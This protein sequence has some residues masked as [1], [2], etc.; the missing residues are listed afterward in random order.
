[1]ATP[2]MLSVRVSLATFVKVVL[3]SFILI[4][5]WALRDIIV[6][7]FLAM[8]LAAAITPWITALARYRIPRPVG[9]VIVYSVI[10]GLIIAVILLMIPVIRTE[11]TALVSSNYYERL[12]TFFQ[13][14]PSKLGPFATKDNLSVLTSGVFSGLKGFLGGFASFLLVLVITFYFTID[15]EN[16]RRFWVRLVPSAHR[17]RVRR[18]ARLAVERIGHWFRGQLVISLVIAS[19]SYLVYTILGVPAALLLAL[20]SGGAA[21]VP[22]IGAIIGIVPAVLLALTVSQVTAVI[23]LILG[24]A[25]YQLTANALIPKIMSRAVGLNPVIIVIV[26]LIGAQL[27]GAVGLILA[28]PITSIIDVIV[29]EM[30][31]EHE[32]EELRHVT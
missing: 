14:N 30:R 23:V 19:L 26:M 12:V 10:L 27:A 18:I 29:R 8:I 9:V 2:T 20:I 32:L 25:I 5:L 4:V 16:I 1:M 17:D 3:I 7:I 6:L 24:I 11:A 22:I 15:E 28:I 13:D 21:F 31:S